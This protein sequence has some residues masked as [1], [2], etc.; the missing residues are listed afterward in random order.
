[1]KATERLALTD[2]IGRELQDRYSYREIDEYLAEYQIPAPTDVTVNSKW[3]YAKAA[4]K[5]ADIGT[6]VT[7]ADDLGV[8]LAIKKQNDCPN[9][10]KSTN[11]FRLFISHISAEKTKAVRLKNVLEPLGISGFVAHEDIH[12]TLE[13]QG[14]IE[15]ALHTMEVFVSMHTV[16]FSKSIWTQQEIGFAVGRNIKIVALRMGEDPTG[17]IS[18]RQALNR[19]SRTAE[20]IASEIDRLLLDD[21]I[22]NA[23]LTQIKAAMAPAEES[24]IPF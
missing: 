1:M 11:H 6:L 23:R 21:P 2:R 3:I 13:W 7:I 20:E 24:E 19:G 8:D 16:G 22:T 12:P 4:L 14:E 9:N 5:N 18:K 17:F 15:R 10:W